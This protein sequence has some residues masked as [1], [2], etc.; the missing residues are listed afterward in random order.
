MSQGRQYFTFYHSVTFG[1]QEGQRCFE[2]TNKHRMLALLVKFKWN[3]RL[4]SVRSKILRGMLCSLTPAAFNSLIW[5]SS[6]A[7]LATIASRNSKFIAPA[8]SRCKLY[9]F[10]S[11]PA[12]SLVETSE[13]ISARIFVR[14]GV[15]YFIEDEVHRWST[16]FY[17]WFP[18]P[19]QR[20]CICCYTWSWKTRSE[21]FIPS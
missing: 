18:P 17:Y 8:T 6:N 3:S 19:I 11:Y 13:L 16:S 15:Y 5:L 10:S 1:C 9:I 14:I 7:E 2:A 12:K 4:S 20:V 21:T